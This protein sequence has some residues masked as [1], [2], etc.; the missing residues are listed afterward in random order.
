MRKLGPK[1]TE[2]Q[3][4]YEEAGIFDS[5]MDRKIKAKVKR[6]KMNFY[7]MEVKHELSVWA[8]F[9]WRKRKR[10][11]SSK[12]GQYLHRS[13]LRSLPHGFFSQILQS[14]S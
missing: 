10:V 6:A 9:N 1:Q 13:S 4:A 3:E 7:F 8:E 12:I 2:L 14:F 5:V 11:S